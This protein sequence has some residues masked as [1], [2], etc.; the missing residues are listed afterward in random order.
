MAQ[1]ALNLTKSRSSKVDQSTGT[2]TSARGLGAARIK[3]SDNLKADFF[4]CILTNDAFTLSEILDELPEDETKA[5]LSKVHSSGH[6]CT[7]MAAKMNR[8]LILTV[9]LEKGADVNQTDIVGNTAL[10]IAAWFNFMGCFKV[11]VKHPKVDVNMGNEYG[12]TALMWACMYGRMQIVR[13]ILRYL[14]PEAVKYESPDGDTPM[15]ISQSYERANVTK[16]LVLY[17]LDM[18]KDPSERSEQF[19]PV[20]NTEDDSKD[21]DDD[22]D[23]DDDEA[24]PTVKEGKE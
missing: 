24:L 13:L 12:E 4:E 23:D 20:V 17:E 2:M 1:I 6:S 22:G 7:T 18:K 16:L 19:R 11:L 3:R 8:K 10:I 21:K 5:L 14:D 15:S 9:L